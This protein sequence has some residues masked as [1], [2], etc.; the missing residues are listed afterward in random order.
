MPLRLVFMGTPDFAVPTLTEI[1]GRGHT[2]VAVYTETGVMV[3]KMEDGLDTGPIALA[4]ITAV[5]PDATA[6]DMHDQLAPLGGDLMVRALAALE[7]G[8]LAL[9]PQ[10]Q[11]GVTYATK[12]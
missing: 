12:I 5:G 8:T 9:K 10:P 11:A 1:V 2:V 6:G 7:R 3:M 4:E